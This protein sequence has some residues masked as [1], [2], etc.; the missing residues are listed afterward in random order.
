MI[1]KGGVTPQDNATKSRNILTSI[2]SNQVQMVKHFRSEC[3]R[4]EPIYQCRKGNH[5]EK[6][7]SSGASSLSERCPTRNWANAAPRV[8]DYEIILNGILKA[9]DNSNLLE[10][11]SGLPDAMQE[12]LSLPSDDLRVKLEDFTIIIIQGLENVSLIFFREL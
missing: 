1:R 10:T 8:E 11:L 5:R 9:D 12:I 4:H 7:P 6:D 3:H 2:G